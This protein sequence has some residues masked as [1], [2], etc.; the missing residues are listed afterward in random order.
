MA[1]VTITIPDT[2]V[3]RV[4]AALRAAH[5][6]WDALTDGEV[7]KRV[8][9]DHVRMLVVGYEQGVAQEA[10]QDQVDAQAATTLNDMAGIG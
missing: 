1:N 3:P 6:E 2:V 7:F 10:A 4:R 8:V 5:P 9:A